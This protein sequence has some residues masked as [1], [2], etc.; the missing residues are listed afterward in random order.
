M[1][2]SNITRT[3]GPN[4]EIITILPISIKVDRQ[5]SRFF[6]RDENSGREYSIPELERMANAGDPSAQCAMGD[7][8]NTQEPHGDFHKA[9]SWYKK[10][11]AQNHARAL[12][13]MGTFYAVGAEVGANVVEKDFDKAMALFEESAKH[14][15]LD[16]MVRLGQVYIMNDIYDKAI[17][18]LEKADKL[19]HE[20]ANVF[21]DGAKQLKKI[22]DEDSQMKKTFSDISKKYWDN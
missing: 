10:A 17:Y 4:G 2:S 6:A 13:N 15:L 18:W 1:N 20:E 9:F 14:G 11:A 5:T 12:C 3:V 16:A 8:Y 7:Y 21:L 19:G 22:A